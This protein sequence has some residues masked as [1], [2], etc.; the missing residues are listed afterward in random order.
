VFKNDEARLE[1]TAQLLG[2]LTAPELAQV[3]AAYIKQT[4]HDP[5]THIRS[6]GLGQPVARLSSKVELGMLE[7]LDGPRMQAIAGQLAAMV[8]KA[9]AGTLTLADRRE[10]YSTLPMIGLYAPP[11]RAEASDHSLDSQERQLLTK[12]FGA[13]GKGDLDKALKTI[14]RALPLAEVSSSRP[15]AKRIAVV[16]SSHGA[17]WQEL[18]DWAMKMRHEGYELQIFSPNGRPVGFQRDSLSVS[19]S[20][21]SLGFGAPPHL[22]PAGPA[23][24]LAKS[25]LSNTAPAKAFDASQFGAVY[26]AGGLGFNEDVAVARQEKGSQKTPLTAQPDVARMVRTSFERKLP[27]IGLCHGP[28][29]LAAVDVRVDGQTEKLSKGIETASLPPFEG[30]V[31]LTGRKSPQFTLDVNTHKTLADAGAQTNVVADALNMHR[32]VKSQKAGVDVITGPG[33]QAAAPLAKA[34]LEALARRWP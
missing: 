9:K 29:L 14:E 27:I 2:G 31:G 25:L 18:M 28:T 11:V 17:Q 21:H 6:D 13:Q 5:E 1:R 22:D 30:Y 4:G 34:T 26:L 24:A 23:G 12:A 33:P 16:A 15:A 10:Y 3:R 32:V 8:E 7:A 19:S 20:T